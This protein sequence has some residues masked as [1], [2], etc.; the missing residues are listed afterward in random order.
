MVHLDEVNTQ[1]QGKFVYPAASPVAKAY[2]DQLNRTHGIQ[3]QR[4]S[5]IRAALDKADEIKSSK[6]KNAAAVSGQ[7]DELAKQVDADASSATGRDQMRL[8]ALADTLRG[9]SAKL[10]A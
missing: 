6:D 5:A 7:L 9:R 3:A 1:E 8:K 2:L 10:K 4:A